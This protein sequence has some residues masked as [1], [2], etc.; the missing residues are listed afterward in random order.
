MRPLH[1]ITGYRFPGRAMAAA[2]CCVA[3]CRAGLQ[4]QP[5]LPDAAAAAEAMQRADNYWISNNAVGNANWARSAYY[6]GNQRAFRVLANDNYRNWAV[7]WG[8][9]NQW[10]IGTEGPTHADAHCCGQTY[11]DLYRLDPQP[12]YIADIKAKMDAVVAATNVSYWSWIDAFYMAGPTLARLGRLTGDTNYFQ[13]LWLMYDDMKTRRGLFD[14]SESLWYRDGNYT[15]YPAVQTANGQKVFWSR[16]NGWVFAALARVMQQMPT[17]APHYADYATVFQAMAAKLITIQGADGMWRSSLYDAAQF[18]NPETSGTGF[19]TYGMAWGVRNGLLPAADYTN[20]LALA[21]NGLTNLALNADGRVGYVQ[22]VGAAPANPTPS[23]TADFG[24]GAFLLA[25]SELYLLAGDSPA[26]R[27]WAGPDRTLTDSDTNGWETVSLDASETEV[28][29]GSAQAYSWWL[30]TNQV[31]AGITA[32]IN[33]PL[34]SNVVTVKVPGSDGITYTDSATIVVAPVVPAIRLHFD[35][36]DNGL[37]TTDRLAGVSLKLLDGSGAGADLHGPPGSGVAGAGRALDFRSAASQGGTGPI[38][39]TEGNTTI[40]FGTM[41]GFTITMW[42]KPASALLGNGYPRFF[43]LGPNGTTDRGNPGSFQLLNNG[44]LQPTNTSVQCFVNAAQPS[45]SAF[46][47]FNMPTNQWRFVALTYD[48]ATISFFGGSETNPVAL[49]SSASLPAGT[50]PTGGNWS[51]F[52]GNRLARDRAFRGWL[53]DVRLYNSAVPL[54]SLEP[55][56]REALA[57]PI[58]SSRVAGS[59]VVLRLQTR[60]SLSYILEATTNLAPP[61][62]WSSVATNLGDGGVLT[63]MAPVNPGGQN[64]FY[65]YRIGQPGS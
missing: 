47:A 1:A 30:G 29:S 64:G 32:Q 7:N 46:G 27:P 62:A 48:G 44:N 38:A 15:N 41:S 56:R 21:W 45:T 50:L 4:A 55:I 57:E 36:E 5:V 26:I 18:P 19:F 52:V 33:V 31:A 65:R 9:A 24:V 63:N 28:Y 61:A 51:L 58:I 10:K 25:C 13:K 59:N 49:L 23:N 43:S 14:A 8:N 6:T 35:F 11:I 22:G 37:A 3:L 42:I 20:S 39:V 60:A 54:A 16:G 40:D 53:D 34:G 2:V 12:V 17:N